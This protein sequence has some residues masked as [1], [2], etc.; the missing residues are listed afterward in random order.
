[1]LLSAEASVPRH[2]ESHPGAGDHAVPLRARI[3]WASWPPGWCIPPDPLLLP[4]V[5]SSAAHRAEPPRAA[6][7][8]VA[9]GVLPSLA[10]LQLRSH[11]DRT[12][13]LWVNSC[14]PGLRPH[15]CNG[16]NNCPHSM[17]F[18]VRKQMRCCLDECGYYYSYRQT[19][20]DRGLP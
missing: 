11:M 13:T 6:R 17:R 10:H 16:D 14:L 18:G 12:L 15:P 3:P 5:Q 19:C 8:G 9:W 1:M 7:C 4:P 20:D 2:E